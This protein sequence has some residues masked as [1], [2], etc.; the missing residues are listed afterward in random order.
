MYIIIAKKKKE[1]VVTNNLDKIYRFIIKHHAVKIKTIVYPGEARILR[2]ETFLT[3]FYIRSRDASM[4]FDLVEILIKHRSNIRNYV[5]T[6]NLTE[7]FKQY[8]TEEK[9]IQ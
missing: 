4:L 8:E 7:Q 2:K 9:T 6:L 1:F 5:A 3:E